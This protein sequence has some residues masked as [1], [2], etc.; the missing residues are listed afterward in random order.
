[1]NEEKANE[2]YNRIVKEWEARHDKKSLDPEKLKA[3]KKMLLLCPDEDGM[4]RVSIMG[5]ETHL[6]PYED[7]ILNGLM[8]AD[9]EKY[10]KEVRG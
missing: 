4:K 5:G 2:I 7:I 3:V 9:V 1:M 6:V 8:G 10:P